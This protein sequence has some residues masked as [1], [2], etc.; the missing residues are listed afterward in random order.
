[1]KNDK[2]KVGDW[3]KILKLGMND[4]AAQV[5]SITDDEYVVV[6]KEGKYEFRTKLN[7]KKIRKL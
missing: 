5:E 3:V 6:Q 1:M 4:T 2:I 7:K